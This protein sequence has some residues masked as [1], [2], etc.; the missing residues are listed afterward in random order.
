MKI[1]NLTPHEVVLDNG[2]M[3]IAFPPSGNVARVDPITDKVTLDFEVTES[4]K[5]KLPVHQAPKVRVMN[6]PKKKEGTYYIVSSFVAQAVRRD[7]LLSP[8]T[9]NSAIRDE[10][11]RVVSVK[12]FQTYTEQELVEV[13]MA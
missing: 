1:V 5:I 13:E 7:D 11:G 8:L 9:D 3:Q 12:M 4:V 10:N 2:F 6:L